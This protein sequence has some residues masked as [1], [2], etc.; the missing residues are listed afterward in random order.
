M[1]TYTF[2]GLRTCI[3]S[4]VAPNEEEARLAADR[5]DAREWVTEDHAVMD[6]ELEDIVEDG[7]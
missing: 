5:L 2:S 6:I 7:E 3:T 4:I 1:P